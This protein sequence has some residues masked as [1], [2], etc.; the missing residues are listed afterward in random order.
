MNKETIVAKLDHLI[1]R[2]D[3]SDNDKIVAIRMLK[4]ELGNL[5]K[6]ID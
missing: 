4:H 3:I 6:K 2:T 5:D 1:I